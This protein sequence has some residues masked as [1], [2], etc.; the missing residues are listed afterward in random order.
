MRSPLWF[1]LTWLG[2]NPDRP[3]IKD[4]VDPFHG[5]EG[6]NKRGQRVLFDE[7]QGRWVMPQNITDAP[8]VKITK[9]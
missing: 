2:R 3:K 8:A 7:Y 5:M 6:S 4:I 1:I 9:G